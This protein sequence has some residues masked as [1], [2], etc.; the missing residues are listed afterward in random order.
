VIPQ[1]N[2]IVLLLALA[3]ARPTSGYAQFP[4]KGYDVTRFNGTQWVESHIE[5]SQD[6]D[7]KGEVILWS[8]SVDSYCAQLVAAVKDP[9]GNLVTYFSAGSGCIRGLTKT[10]MAETTIHKTLK[11]NGQVPPNYLVSATELDLKAIPDDKAPLTIQLIRQL[12]F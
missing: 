8:Q 3:L 7:I 9:Q 5:V 4:I 1:Q 2:W 10:S 11:V 6:G 12:F